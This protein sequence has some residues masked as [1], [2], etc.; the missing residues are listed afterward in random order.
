MGTGILGGLAVAMVAVALFFVGVVLVYLGGAALQL[1]R[2]IWSELEPMLEHEVLMRR[3]EVRLMIDEAGYQC[4][5]WLDDEADEEDE[6]SKV[7]RLVPKPSTE[8]TE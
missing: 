8:S 6:R 4:P 1:I 5:E 2:E 7:V 3:M